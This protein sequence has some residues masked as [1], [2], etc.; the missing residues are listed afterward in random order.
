MKCP[1]VIPGV[2]LS[3]ERQS[4]NSQLKNCTYALSGL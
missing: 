2:E 4:E 3:I 1:S